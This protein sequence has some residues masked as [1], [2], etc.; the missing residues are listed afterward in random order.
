[1][2]NVHNTALE[3]EWFR[4]RERAVAWLRLGFAILAIA[5]IQL[6]PSRIARYPALSTVTLSSF[7]IYS[8]GAVWLV[9]KDKFPLAS[10]GAIT[11][12]LD[13]IWIAFIV[14]STG[15]TRTPF[16]FYY[17]FPVITA[18]LR[19]GL[20]GS[21]PVALVGVGIYTVTRLSLAAES[22][23][24][25]IGIDTIVVRSL[26]LL[27]LAGIFGYISEFEQKQ[28]RKLLA[29]SHTAGQLATLEERHRIMYELHDGLLQSL[30]TI[31]LRIESIRAQFGVTEKA[32]AGDLR[33]L[34]DLTRGTMSEIRQFLAGKEPTPIAPGTMMQR[35]KDELRFLQGLGMEAMLEA[36][37]EDLDLP[38][39]I[40]RELYYVLREALTNITR[41]AHATRV[42]IQ[43]RQ[44]KDR[45]D[46]SIED[47]GVGSDFS[48]NPNG[49]GIGMASMRDRIEKK[50]GGFNIQSSPGNGF[51]LV[52]SLPLNLPNKAA[53]NQ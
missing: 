12:A 13:T 23:G 27:V 4:E 29:F 51:K 21:L 8:A 38:P 5:V 34:E 31:I 11:T 32:L 35:L 2:N 20:K 10:L 6:N 37:P 39:E 41:H 42:A 47:N 18:S 52:F 24:E 22:G 19:W 45:I 36:D 3:N 33:Q 53:V 43:L 44:G 14:V 48:K 49:I 15:G 40:E 16:F 26:Y 28:N 30:A 9:W 46:G 50:G 1:M 7:L 17:S 25:P